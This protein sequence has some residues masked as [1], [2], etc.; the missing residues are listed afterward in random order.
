MQS[1]KKVNLLVIALVGLGM[2][3]YYKIRFLLSGVIGMQD[4]IHW[5]LPVEVAFSLCLST[6]VVIGHDSIVSGLRAFF[7]DEARAGLRFLI[8]F[9]LSMLFSVLI[10]MVFAIIFWNYVMKM[11]LTDDFIF[12]YA[13]LGM[14]I[15]LLVNGFSESFYFYGR[16]KKESLEKERL[17]KEHIRAKYEVL[18]NQVSPHFLFNCFNTLS[19]LI[20]E[21]K[22]SAKD[23]LQQLSRVYRYVLEVKDREVVELSEEIEAM[24]AYASLMKHRFGES[25]RLKVDIQPNSSYY[26]APLTLQMLLENA[27]KHNECSREKPLEIRIDQRKD[28]LLFIN[29]LQHLV[30]NSPGTGLGL[31]NLANRY[32]LLSGREIEVHSG[33]TDFQVK[34][35]LIKVEE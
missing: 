11:P 15:P 13:V 3:T 2:P 5:T 20:D 22:Q 31:L 28:S 26:L 29:R 19:V 27:L 9:S 24:L 25:F 32:Q 16:W 33:H 17:E 23:F 21:G 10:A 14:L 12:D 1:R 18:Q 30:H 4:I 34:V 7:S 6:L 8:Q 35:P